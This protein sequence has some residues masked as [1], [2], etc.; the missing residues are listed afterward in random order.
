MYGIQGR[1]RAM[2]NREKVLKALSICLPETEEESEQSCARCPYLK[3]CNCFD[4]V[5]IPARLLEDVRAVLSE[6]ET[7]AANGRRYRGDGDD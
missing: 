1:V 7:V 4:T 3:S 5:D 6:R 2:N